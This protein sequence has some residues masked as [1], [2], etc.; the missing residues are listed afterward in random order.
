MV[1]KILETDSQK[2]RTRYQDFV[3]NY[4]NIEGLLL[5]TLIRDTLA[6]FQG[7]LI[8]PNELI[9]I[10]GNPEK[11][12][13]VGLYLHILL[14]LGLIYLCTGQADILSERIGYHNDPSFRR[15]YPSHHCNI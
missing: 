2:K 13:N 7:Q 15:R 10:G 4:E 9:E 12:P 1:T 5:G 6:I 14:I 11:G 8:G 3:N